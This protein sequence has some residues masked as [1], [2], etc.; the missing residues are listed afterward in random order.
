EFPGPSFGVAGIR[1]RL[2]VDDRPIFCRSM[3]PAVGLD[4]ETMLKINREVLLG[5]FDAVKDDELT[6]D[7]PRSPFQERV[8]KMVEMK[9]DVE[10][11]SGKKKLYFANVIDDY[12]KSLE[13]AAQAAELGADG[14]LVSPALQGLSILSDTARKTDLIIISHNSCSD[15]MTRHPG[16]GVTD[17]VMARLQCLC[18][19]D[20]VMT[21]GGAGSD[22]ELP[23]VT[24][25]FLLGCRE[26]FD[27]TPES[28]PVF[29]G[30]KTPADIQ[31]CRQSA[32]SDDFMIIAAS[33][34]D[35]HEEGIAA[36]AAAYLEAV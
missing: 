8:K 24:R 7:T 25:G 14:V 3:R 34:L 26:P 35:S 31:K 19:A 17:K 12:L 32:G 16:W 21:P 18:G 27:D 33:W 4:T 5:G 11:Q 28:L 10:Q 13:L 6:Y 29:M 22:H 15:L 23:G 20:L 2:R 1:D 36:A 30:G 9:Q